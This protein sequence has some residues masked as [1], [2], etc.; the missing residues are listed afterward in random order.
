LYRLCGLEIFCRRRVHD[1]V[2]VP[3]HVGGTLVTVYPQPSARTHQPGH[4]RSCL[5]VVKYRGWSHVFLHGFRTTMTSFVLFFKDS[6]YS[7]YS[8][9]IL[10]PSCTSN[11]CCPKVHNA[12]VTLNAVTNQ[13]HM[14]RHKKY[15]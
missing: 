3:Q 10:L 6:R 15:T 8:P 2:H 9:R 1:V 11:V 12:H 5:L 4:F 13:C 7:R 14:F